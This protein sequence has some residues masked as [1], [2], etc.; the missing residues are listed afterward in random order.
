MDSY[1]PD[2]KPSYDNKKMYENDKYSFEKP[3]YEKENCYLKNYDLFFKINKRIDKIQEI[4]NIYKTNYFMIKHHLKTDY[5]SELI[6]I[7]NKYLYKINDIAR[8][9]YQNYE[10][11]EIKFE[12][13]LKIEDIEDM[14]W[15]KEISKLYY[16]EDSKS[17]T[18]LESILENLFEFNNLL[19]MFYID[20]MDKIDLTIRRK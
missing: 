3:L 11:T 18:E 9:S 12:D 8:F 6:K 7:I 2:V 1:L 5:L 10:E 17:T 13:L 15:Y 19:E 16:L 14:L 4:F 20:L